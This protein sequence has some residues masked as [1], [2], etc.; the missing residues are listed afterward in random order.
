M[1]AYNTI[2]FF[3]ACCILKLPSAAAECMYVCMDGCMYGCMDVNECFYIPV[4]IHVS[5]DIQTYK[6]T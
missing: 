5:V 4:C 2:Y 1:Y 3:F 6:D